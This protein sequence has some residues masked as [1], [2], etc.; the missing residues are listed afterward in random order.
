MKRYIPASLNGLASLLFLALWCGSAYGVDLQPNDIVAPLPNKNYLSLSYQNSQNTTFY[1][2]GSVVTTRPYGNPVIDTNAAF[3]RVSTTYEIA[4]LP[5]VS[6]VQLPYGSITTAGSLSSYAGDTGFGDI[7]LATAI[8]PYS[9]RESRTYLG[10]AGYF[11][12]PT[13]KYSNQTVFNVGENRYK[14]D[15]Q[16]GFQRPIVDSVDAAIAVDTMWYGGNSQ[17]AALCGST[18]NQSLT[19]KPLTTIQAGPIYKINQ[20]YTV[21]ATYFYVAGGA[22]LINNQYQNNV[23]NTQRYL[24]S[25]QAHTPIGRF[26]LQYGRDMEIK[27]GFMQSRLLLA[28]YSVEF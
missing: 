2:N 16:M 7:S 5:G 3:A 24:L 20:I 26:S 12:M 17:C 1:K 21:A 6:Y 28:R 15:I 23:I 25:G 8:W 10:V 19:Q 13:S 27:N 22:T 11:L 14:S 18:T 4:S 9:N